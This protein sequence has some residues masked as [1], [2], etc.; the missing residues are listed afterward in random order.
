LSL[1]RR[2]AAPGTQA[3]ATGLY[4]SPFCSETIATSMYGRVVVLL[5]LGFAFA[6]APLSSGDD[7]EQ[8]IGEVLDHLESARACQMLMSSCSKQRSRP[9]ERD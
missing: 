5:V 3:L 8:G 4:L 9:R 7:I 1:N 2:F 6:M